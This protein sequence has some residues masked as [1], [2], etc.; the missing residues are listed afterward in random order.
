MRL[1]NAQT[2][3]VQLGRVAL[4][5][6]HGTDRAVP[7]AGGWS[8]TGRS[9]SR[10]LLQHA[11]VSEVCMRTVLTHTERAHIAARY[12]PPPA[13]C[14]TH[15][16]SASPSQTPA[17]TRPTPTQGRCARR[18]DRPAQGLR[19][20]KGRAA[21]FVPREGSAD[22]RIEDRMADGCGVPCMDSEA[23][24]SL[25]LQDETGVGTIV[26]V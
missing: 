23:V 19:W 2:F 3:S 12:R 20:C 14:F 18:N 6:S 4:T 9:V 15:R 25:C 10:L 22:A 1:S 7:S 13:A 26:G 16:P 21:Y 8:Q 17:P 5:R 24:R 11:K